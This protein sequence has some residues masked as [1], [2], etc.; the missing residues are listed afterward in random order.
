HGQNSG[1]YRNAKA[2]RAMEAARRETD[3]ARRLAFYR[4]VDRLLAADP[5]ADFLWGADQ[6]WGLSRKLTGVAVSSL[7]LFHFLPGPLGWRPVTDGATARGHSRAFSCSI[8]PGCWPDRSVRCCSATW[9]RASSRSSIPT[10]ATSR[11]GGALPGNPRP[12]FR[13]TTWPS[14]ATK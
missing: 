6:F 7:G 9:G 1:F 14:T 12:G 4:E 8:S 3:A 2:D 13:P 11:A 5:P 10:A